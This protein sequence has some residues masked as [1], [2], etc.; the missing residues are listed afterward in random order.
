VVTPVRGLMI[1]W[2]NVTLVSLPVSVP[3]N[4][5]PARLGAKAP[6]NEPEARCWA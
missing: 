3:P 6:E 2:R 4:R 5:M 1:A